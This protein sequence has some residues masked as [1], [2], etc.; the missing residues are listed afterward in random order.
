MKTKI[1][2][3]S[4]LL[5]EN[6]APA[7]L[8]SAAANGVATHFKK[9]GGDL[10]VIFGE[11][12]L[13]HQDLEDPIKEINLQQYCQMFEIAAK[14]TGNCN[15]GLHFGQ[16]FLPKQL[17]MIG[18]IATSSP[19]LGTGL[20]YM[21]KYF[22]AH[23]ELSRFSL[24]HEDD[25]VWLSYRILDPRIK[26]KRQDAELSLGM[27]CN[28]FKESLGKNWSPL[29]IRFEH[30]ETD[31]YKEHESR[32]NCPVEFGRRTNAIAFRKKDLEAK[33]PN[34]DPYLFSIVKSFLENR[35]S[36][37]SPTDFSMIVRNEIA[38]QLGSTIPTMEQIAS[39]L[40]LSNKNFQ[41]KLKFNKIKYA[42]ILKAARIDLALHYMDDPE[43]PL[44][45]IAFNLG[46]SE[47]SAFSRAFRNWTGISPQK[48]RRNY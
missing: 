43:I 44:T 48:Y 39:V 35:S 17:G 2:N 42:N 38:M 26:K 11:S 7:K 13:N 20:G 1:K 33:M 40:G 9:N 31:G 32:F 41:K 14:N 25:I 45:E 37:K 5:R 8:L 12:G 10:D 18:Y 47:L 6:F 24:I 46:Y 28:I 34:C 15:I 19:T 22:S 16:K 23:Q 36:S 21:E 29:E 27:F 4:S 3:D 30:L